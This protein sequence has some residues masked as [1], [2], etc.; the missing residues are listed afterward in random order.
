MPVT[1]TLTC[2]DEA[3]FF[4]KCENSLAVILARSRDQRIASGERIAEYP[5]LSMRDIQ[6]VP[7]QRKIEVD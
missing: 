1:R 2:G 4:C 3:L 5:T 6:H 7:Q